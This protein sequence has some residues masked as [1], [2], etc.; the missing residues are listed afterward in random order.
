M[1][2]MKHLKIDSENSLVTKSEPPIP[3]LTTSVIDLFE[4]PFQFPE[5]TC[6]EFKIDYRNM[7]E[8]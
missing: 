5:M 4:Y 6:R 7:G 2:L 8:Y 3:I 1:L